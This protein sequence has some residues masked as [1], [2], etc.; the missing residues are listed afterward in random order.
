MCPAAN[1]M[2]IQ[3]VLKFTQA[4]MTLLASHWD[5]CVKESSL[6][7]AP[8]KYHANPIRRENCYYVL[9]DNTSFCIKKASGVI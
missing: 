8:P 4:E 2:H 7:V 6:C 5:A 1:N 9:D 3:G